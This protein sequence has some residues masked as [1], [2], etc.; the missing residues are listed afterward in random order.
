MSNCTTDLL[1][2][3]Y[4]EPL[5]LSLAVGRYYV[6]S[7]EDAR[8]GGDHSLVM[9]DSAA[10][11]TITHR[12]ASTLMTYASSG[13]IS[14][15]VLSQPGGQASPKWTVV[16]QVDTSYGVLNLLTGPSMT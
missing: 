15:R 2:I 9:T 14:G 10:A 16:S 12:D 7:W 8:G 11:T 1:N 5:D 13:V 4:S 6:V 3:C